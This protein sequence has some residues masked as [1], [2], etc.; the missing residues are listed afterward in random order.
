M[1][2]RGEQGFT[3]LEMI[4]CLSILS[5]FF[6]IAPPL[7]HVQSKQTAPF[8]ELEWLLYIEQ[9]QIEFREAQGVQACDRRLVL[10]DKTG[11]VVSHTMQGINVIRKVGDKGHEVA[12]QRIKRISYICYPTYLIVTAEDHGGQIHTGMVTTFRKE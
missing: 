6:V 10:T 1:S 2:V 3:L 12:L 7:F 9:L 11:N 4:M 8:N 5:L